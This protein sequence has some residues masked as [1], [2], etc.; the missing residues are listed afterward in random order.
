MGASSLDA[1][2]LSAFCYSATVQ[3]LQSE[4]L[5]VPRPLLRCAVYRNSRYLSTHSMT[6]ITN[7]K[8]SKTLKSLRFS[9]SS[10]FYEENLA[11]GS[12]QPRSGNPRNRAGRLARRVRSL[13][14]KQRGTE[15]CIGFQT[16]INACS[17]GRS[18]RWN[19][20]CD[21]AG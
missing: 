10:P 8:K 12:I 11:H 6:I 18:G 19:G 2:I 4:L 15:Y 5:I 17:L 16:T 14:T 21:E 13:P 9:D 20:R 1:P 3:K 7:R